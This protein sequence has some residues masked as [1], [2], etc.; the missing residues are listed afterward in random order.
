MLML[1][2]YPE[3]SDEEELEQ[4][5]GVCSIKKFH[6][7]SDTQPELAACHLRGYL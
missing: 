2:L 1:E 6:R 5:L 7:C 3:S 4:K